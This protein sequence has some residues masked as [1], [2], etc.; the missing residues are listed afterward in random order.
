MIMIFNKE[1]KYI[2]FKLF[3]FKN[4]FRNLNLNFIKFES[5]YNNGNRIL[6]IGNIS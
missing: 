6:L 2:F 3:I 4:K 1:K 5:D